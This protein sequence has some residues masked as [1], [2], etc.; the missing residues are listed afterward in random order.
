MHES[1]AEYFRVR[2][3]DIYYYLEDDSISV[4]E[5]HVENSGM[6]QGKDFKPNC[7]KQSQHLQ[8]LFIN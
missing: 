8:D 6:P 1:P 7:E 5:P 2:P 4:V 3:V